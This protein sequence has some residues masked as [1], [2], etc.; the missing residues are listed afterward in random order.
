MS[1]KTHHRESDSSFGN[2]LFPAEHEQWGQHSLGGRE[3][4]F[5]ER[6]AT[7]ASNVTRADYLTGYQINP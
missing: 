7:D 1:F 3:V 5:G 4:E 6:K 2:L